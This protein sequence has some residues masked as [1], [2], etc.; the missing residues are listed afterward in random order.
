MA[1]A[2]ELPTA[3]THLDVILPKHLVARIVRFLQR[4]DG[5][6]LAHGHQAG[7]QNNRMRP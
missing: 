5:L 3:A 7:L 4:F 2:N 1:G 6:G